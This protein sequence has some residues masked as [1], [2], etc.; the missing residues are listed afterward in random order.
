MTTFIEGFADETGST[1][2]EADWAW[3][4]WSRQL[5]NA[6]RARIEAQGYRAGRAEGSLYCSAFGAS[7]NEC[8]EAN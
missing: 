7:R 5:P 6:E 1:L 3:A 4:A 8:I 2:V